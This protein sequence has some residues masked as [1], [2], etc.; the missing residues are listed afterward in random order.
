MTQLTIIKIL[1]ITGIILLVTLA[2]MLM[3]CDET[4]D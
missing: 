2:I 3:M 1:F 4:R